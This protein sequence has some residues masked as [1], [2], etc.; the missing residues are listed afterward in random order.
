MAMPFGVLPPPRYYLYLDAVA[1]AGSIRK[2]AVNLHVAST[3]LNRKINEI[4]DL[5]GT[6]LFERLPRGV[7]PT[8]AG[9]VLLA[10]VRRS[11]TDMRSA[12]SQIEQLR[13]QVRG[14]VH[15]GCAESVATDMVPHCISQYQ[16]THP[17]VQFRMATGV[18]GELV[19]QLLRDDVDLVL[20]HEPPASEQLKTIISVRQPLCAMVRPDHP[21]ADRASVRMADCQKYPV[22]LANQ[23]FGTRRLIDAL[24]AKSRLRLSVVLESS[25]IGALKEFTRLTGAISFQYRIGTLREVQRGELVAI[26]L[27]DRSL[28]NTRLV[29]ASRNGRALPVP[30]LTFA[31]IIEQRLAQL[32][33]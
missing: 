32:P 15:I 2:A 7:R 25:T 9:E 23:S 27:A 30:S 20:V 24:V 11:M 33:D 29:L 1:R 6:P 14:V 28:A 3:A 5:I 22:A 31:H 8:A 16:T 21:L 10:T 4:E 13:G 18:T 19:Q 12:M 26:P 17:G